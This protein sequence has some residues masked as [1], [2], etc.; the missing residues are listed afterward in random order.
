MFPDLG[1]GGLP[2][3]V[4]L[5]LAVAGDREAE[6][7]PRRRVRESCAEAARTGHGTALFRCGDLAPR[8]LPSSPSTA[9]PAGP[10]PGAA[11]TRE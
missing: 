8:V 3:F 6:G 2:Q 10:P 5:D 9:R 11:P 1:T 4:V 7:E